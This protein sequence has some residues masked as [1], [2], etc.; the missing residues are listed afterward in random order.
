MV[1]VG[2]NALMATTEVHAM[3][4]AQK[5]ARTTCAAAVQ[6][7]VSI[8]L[9]DFMVASVSIDVMTTVTILIVTCKSVYV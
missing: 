9:M 6:V 1:I 3:K 4:N 2:L 5:T 7:N 8:A